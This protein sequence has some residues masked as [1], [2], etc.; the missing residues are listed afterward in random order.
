[1][2]R[3]L[4]FTNFNIKLKIEIDGGINPSVSKKLKEFGAD[5]LVSGSYVY[6]SKNR[7][8]AINDLRWT[9]NLLI[10]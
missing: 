4:W 9:F 8:L 7:L 5:I 1:M 2:V 10:A 3:K 6:N